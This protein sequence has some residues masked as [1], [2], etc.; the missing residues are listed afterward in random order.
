MG[1]IYERFAGPQDGDPWVMRP[2]G[3]V[4]KSSRD[5]DK[6]DAPQKKTG[7]RIWIWL[8]TQRGLKGQLN[9][10]F[11]ELR[12]ASLDKRTIE[13]AIKLRQGVTARVQ[14]ARL[15]FFSDYP[16]IH[17]V[18]QKI[19]GKV[20]CEVL[21]FYGLDSVKIHASFKKL[22]VGEIRKP[23]A[24]EHERIDSTVAQFEVNLH[25]AVS[26]KGLSEAALRTLNAADLKEPAALRWL[27]R[28][29]IVEG[30]LRQS[31]WSNKDI[32][33]WHVKMAQAGH[34]GSWLRLQLLHPATHS[35]RIDSSADVARTRAKG[36]EEVDKQMANMAVHVYRSGRYIVDL[37]ESARSMEVAAEPTASPERSPS[38]STEGTATT[39]IEVPPETMS[40]AEKEEMQRLSGLAEKGDVEAA[41]Q[42]VDTY[43]KRAWEIL[44]RPEMTPIR[45]RLVVELLDQ[46]VDIARQY[47]KPKDPEKPEGGRRGEADRGAYWDHYFK[48]ARSLAVVHHSQDIVKDMCQ[49]STRNPSEVVDAIMGMSRVS[50]GVA[51]WDVVYACDWAAGKGVPGMS[52]KLTNFVLL[53]RNIRGLRRAFERMNDSEKI[54]TRMLED[55]ASTLFELRQL[56]RIAHLYQQV[57]SSDDVQGPSRS[58]VSTY[59]AGSPFDAMSA[60]LLI[61]ENS[62]YAPQARIEAYLAMAKEARQGKKDT[63]AKSYLKAAQ[64][65]A[66]SVPLSDQDSLQEALIVLLVDPTVSC[67]EAFAK[68]LRSVLTALNAEIAID[69]EIDR[70]P[71]RL[72]AVARQQT[73]IRYGQQGAVRALLGLDPEAAFALL[74][75]LPKEVEAAVAMRSTMEAFITRKLQRSGREEDALAWSRFLVRLV[76]LDQVVAHMTSC[77]A[78]LQAAEKLMLSQRKSPMEVLSWQF[79][80]AEK[81]DRVCFDRLKHLRESLS[82]TDPLEAAIADFDQAKLNQ[83]EKSRYE[84]LADKAATGDK[85]AMDELI[86]Y[87]PE[88]TRLASYAERMRTSDLLEPLIEKVTVWL[89]DELSRRGEAEQGIPMRQYVQI[90]QLL[91]SGSSSPVSLST[92]SGQLEKE[93]FIAWLC[94]RSMEGSSAAIRGLIQ[95][96]PLTAAGVLLANRKNRLADDSTLFSDYSELERQCE[97]R[98]AGVV[99]STK[100]L[101]EALLYLNTMR[102]MGSYIALYEALNKNTALKSEI[103]DNLNADKDWTE[104]FSPRDPFYP[105]RTSD[106]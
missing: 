75:S 106:S 2:E 99:A 15:G 95:V 94:R 103:W 51:V 17:R 30:D 93:V 89:M 12:T 42:L 63:L 62:A 34:Q 9:R 90:L 23:D 27:E 45:D 69:Q 43:P 1:S 98:L 49:K 77:L 50:T 74:K 33:E 60:F 52:D 54:Q 4:P 48:L 13:G 44:R 72:A 25:A 97:V 47:D 5:V 78:C 8:R 39:T 32:I 57:P 56:Q 84:S 20:D 104:Y 55:P 81:G 82:K 16:A 88:W 64:K 68:D 79:A 22:I 91:D 67:D 66:E 37:S 105:R 40:E 38:S 80:C 53:D 58:I 71:K 100:S 19:L 21:H 73:L 101:K 70:V 31:G 36:I 11:K 86:Q 24:S 102:G 87:V 10:I 61:A 7:W 35:E 46:M 29:R 83:L 96:D 6:S 26:G 28:M 76:P 59:G 85:G 18:Q 14:T 92:R 41:K 65:V 3:L